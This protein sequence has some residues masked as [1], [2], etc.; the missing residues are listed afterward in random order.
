MKNHLTKISVAVSAPLLV[1]IVAAAQE[2]RFD[3][4]AW[5]H[6]VEVLAADDMEGRGIDTPG[7]SAPRPTSSIS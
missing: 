1:M 7:W 2:Q 5:W 3:G 6:H 4:K